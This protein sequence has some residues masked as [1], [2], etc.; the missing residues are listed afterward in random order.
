MCRISFCC[1]ILPMERAKDRLSALL[2]PKWCC[3][4]TP[5][6]Q[7]ILLQPPN[8]RMLS[9]REAAES[10]RWWIAERAR[11]G[12]RQSSAPGGCGS[13]SPHEPTPDFP[14]TSCHLQVGIV[15]TTKYIPRGGMRTNLSE[16]HADLTKGE[17][18]PRGQ[19][20][21]EPPQLLST[22]DPHLEALGLGKPLRPAK[23]TSLSLCARRALELRPLRLRGQGRAAKFSSARGGPAGV[24]AEMLAHED[25][26]SVSL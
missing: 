13:N 15:S 21:E 25:V 23:G 2:V 11:R 24:N 19:Q 7:Y 4:K 22:C 12:Q 10:V 3:R 18:I 5:T 6:R 26:S 9:P 20:S 1:V 14:T 17:R 16:P 8:R